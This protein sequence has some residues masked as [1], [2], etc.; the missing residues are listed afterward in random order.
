MEGFMLFDG[1]D[2]VRTLHPLELECLS[3][4]GDIDFPCVTEGEIQ[5]KSKGDVL[6]KG[7]VVI[8]TAWFLLQCI[9]R[10][11]ERL[12]ITELEIMTLA[13]ATLNLITYGFW[14]HK[15]LNVQRPIRVF[16]NQRQ[17]KG[18]TDQKQQR[19]NGRPTFGTLDSPTDAVHSNAASHEVS[20]SLSHP[21]WSAATIYCEIWGRAICTAYY[22]CSDGWGIVWNG[23]EAVSG[24]RPLDSFGRIAGLDGDFKAGEKGIPAF[25]SGGLENDEDARSNIV[26]MVTAMIFGAVHCIAWS[27]QFPSH[28][29]QLSWRL[30]SLSITCLPM[31]PWLAVL[32]ENRTVIRLAGRSILGVGNFLFFGLTVGSVVLY[33]ISRIML[34]VI[35]FSSLR[36]LSLGTYKTVHWTTFI[37]H[38]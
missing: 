26:A 13:F 22:V 9:A 11:V 16:R 2:A 35:A 31:C 25:Y 4:S 15:P 12:P 30:A 29:E 36:S 10:G 1:D 8:Q 28:S 23:V 24:Y 19:G 18:K 32:L 20:A 37:P 27:F 14:W 6:S 5:D 33:C 3:V 38:I 34:L 7:L 17:G 21:S